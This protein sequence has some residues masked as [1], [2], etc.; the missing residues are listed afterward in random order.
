[1]TY[2]SNKAFTIRVQKY[3]LKKEFKNKVIF[4][5]YVVK[6]IYDESLRWQINTTYTLEKYSLIPKAKQPKRNW[7]SNI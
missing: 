5:C 6:T 1:M 4:V 3:I 2:Y 7:Y